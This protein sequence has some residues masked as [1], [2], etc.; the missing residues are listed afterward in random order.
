MRSPSRDD[1]AVFRKTFF[2][3]LLLIKEDGKLAAAAA[4]Q[5][6]HTFTDVLKC[7]TVTGQS[8]VDIV[9]NICDILPGKGSKWE[10]KPRLLLLPRL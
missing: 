7:E 9:T 8:K 10:S 5:A 3:H 2:P 1:I 6:A 4:P